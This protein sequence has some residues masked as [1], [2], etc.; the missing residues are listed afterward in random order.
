MHLRIWFET[1]LHVPVPG[2]SYEESINIAHFQTIDCMGQSMLTPLP[3]NIYYNVVVNSIRLN[4]NMSVHCSRHSVWGFLNTF[5]GILFDNFYILLWKSLFVKKSR[6]S[7]CTSICCLIFWLFFLL[8]KFYLTFL[9]RKNWLIIHSL[10]PPPHWY[11][12]EWCI[13][14]ICLTWH[15]IRE[16]INIH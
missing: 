3:D 13:Y 9:V 4:Y 10:A 2:G 5:Y 1:T 11:I 14:W 8:F 6:V 12:C 7:L 15:M 16:K